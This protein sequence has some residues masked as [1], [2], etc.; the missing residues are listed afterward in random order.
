[1]WTYVTKC[2]CRSRH[3]IQWTFTT[4]EIMF[5]CRETFTHDVWNV[6]IQWNVHDMWT[7]DIQWNVVDMWNVVNV[8]R[9]MIQYDFKN[10]HDMW[11]IA[12]HVHM[13]RNAH[14]IDW[15]L[16]PSYL[17]TTFL[18]FICS[19]LFFTTCENM[20]NVKN[21]SRHVKCRHFTCRETWHWMRH[22][23]REVGGWGRDPKKCTGR[24]WGMGSSTI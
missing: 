1:M 16:T 11:N 14:D 8:S 12:T 20:W 15:M 4:C 6:D 22:S 19:R 3:V 7:V 23:R 2:E 17:F 24:D 21:V 13:S 9:H 18:M 10:I 5:T